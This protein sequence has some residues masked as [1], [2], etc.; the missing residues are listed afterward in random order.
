MDKPSDIIAEKSVSALLDNAKMARISKMILGL[1]GQ[2][3]AKLSKK[4]IGGQWI[5]GKAYLTN[6]GFEFH[7]G[8]LNRPFFKNMDELC[9]RLNWS[10]VTGLS[11]RF[12]MVSPIIDLNTATETHSIRC[13]G[14]DEF[15]HRM[16][17]LRTG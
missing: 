6:A 4:M 8:L 7:P 17:T 2:I 16:D 10:E 5:S 12:G 13:N 9:L 3:S 1:D 11:K 14:A 15:L